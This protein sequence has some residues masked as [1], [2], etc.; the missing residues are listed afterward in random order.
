MLKFI[1][2]LFVTSSFINFAVADIAVIVNVNNTSSFNKN[3]I[4]KLFLGKSKKFT[5]GE[6]CIPIDLTQGSLI[7]TQ[8]R[9]SMINKTSSQ[10]KAYWS[11]KIFTGKGKPPSQYESSALAKMFVQNNANAIGYIDESLG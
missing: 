2:C 10:L 1:L 6:K 9:Q 7:A 3:S 11:K 4:T 8:F 5:N